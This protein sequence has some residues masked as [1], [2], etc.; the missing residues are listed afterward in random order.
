M[1]ERNANYPKGIDMGPQRVVRSL[2]E[3]SIIT[4]VSGHFTGGLPENISKNKA[5]ES[6]GFRR[7][8]HSEHPPAKK[9][10]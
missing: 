9:H 8:H 6:F 2:S 7:D 4:A 3:E 10:E 5:F 1:E